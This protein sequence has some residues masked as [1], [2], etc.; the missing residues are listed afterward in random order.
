MEVFNACIFPV[1]IR[2]LPA[3]RRF[4]VRCE[5]IE[6]FLADGKA[7]G[8]E[9]FHVHLHVFPRFRGDAFRLEADWSVA[10]HRAALDRIAARLRAAAS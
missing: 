1:G 8:Q 9:V 5:E 10:P 2:L 7:A 3:L 6:P 4:G